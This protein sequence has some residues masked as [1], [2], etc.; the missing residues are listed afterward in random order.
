LD[1]PRTK[2]PS[3]VEIAIPSE[4]IRHPFVEIPDSKRGHVLVTLIE[5][6]GPSNKRH[7]VDWEAYEAKQQEVLHSDASLVEVV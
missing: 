1:A 5:I 4:P 7:G 2:A 3:S 6:D